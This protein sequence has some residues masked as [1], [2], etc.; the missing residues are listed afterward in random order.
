MCAPC[1]AQLSSYVLPFCSVC[2]DLLEVRSSFGPPELLPDALDRGVHLSSSDNVGMYTG[3][4][5]DPL[6]YD[7]W[8]YDEL[9]G[10]AAHGLGRRLRESFSS[11]RD[12]LYEAGKG[13]WRRS[14]DQWIQEAVALGVLSFFASGVLRVV[15]GLWLFLKNVCGLTD[16]WSLGL[17]TLLLFLAMKCGG[18][19]ALQGWD[20]G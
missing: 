14:A 10:S 6:E 19:T 1:A 11:W 2:R 7:D 12:F 8:K 20:D 4:G 3:K 15:P 17:V 9:R 5:R 13:L 16:N 18:W